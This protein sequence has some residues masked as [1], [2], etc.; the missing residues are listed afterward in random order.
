MK[1]REIAMELL[2]PHCLK[3]VTVADDKAGQVLNC[4]L[5][6]GVF[7]APSLAPPPVRM[8]A[9]PP[10]SP[11]SSPPVPAPPPQ[12]PNM[13]IPMQPAS[14]APA[15]M[16]PP[17]VA[18]TPPPPPKPAPPP[19]DYTRRYAIRLRADVLI[20][21][22]PACLFLIVFVFSFF[23]WHS[24]SEVVN[25]YIPLSLWDLMIGSRS[26][27]M[28]M[29]Y[30]PFTILAFLASVACVVFEFGLAPT[31]PQLA[32]LMPWKS[33]ITFALLGL[34]FLLFAYDYQLGMMA[35]SATS[36]IVLGEKIAFRLHLIALIASGLELWVQS[37][38][39]R[40]LPLPRFTLK[41]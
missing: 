12:I 9:S 13:E 40:N 38:R 25:V 18:P 31:P 6:Q 3:K 20:C 29:A 15:P 41:L 32:S 16:P 39:V 24:I 17:Y 26:T 1:E 5:C 2:C 30:V 14:P 34:T 11:P 8:S 36:P 37:R 7:A 23:P 21:I 35:M 10:S 22:P 19:A 27:S 28:F 4:P 33:G